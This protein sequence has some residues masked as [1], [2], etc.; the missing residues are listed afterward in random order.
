MPVPVRRVGEPAAGVRGKA[1]GDSLLPGSQ[2]VDGEAP[3]PEAISTGRVEESRPTL[4]DSIG[5]R[6]ETEVTE[7]A[8]N[9]TGVPCW[10][11]V[12]TQTLVAAERK[13]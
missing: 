5:G 3:R 10:A 1:S 4:N 7:M 9:P 8:V 6:T 11:P 12:M 13:A 2:Q